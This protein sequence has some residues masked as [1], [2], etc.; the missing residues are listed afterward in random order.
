V[1]CEAGVLI[2]FESPVVSKNS[3]LLFDTDGDLNPDSSDSDDDNDG[4]S[5]DIEIQVGSDSKDPDSVPPDHDS[6]FV[7]DSIDT[8]DDNDGVPDK[9]D[10]F[11]KDKS[12]QRDLTLVL[13]YALIAVILIVVMT[14]VAARKRSSI[15]GFDTEIDYDSDDE[16]DIGKKDINGDLEDKVLDE[17]ES[18]LLK[19]D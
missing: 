18:E 7:P 15:K 14:V 2:E 5:D 19:D 3:S 9:Y 11:P 17:D 8:D 6:D 16:F 10:D 12:R 1:D 4:Y 13:I